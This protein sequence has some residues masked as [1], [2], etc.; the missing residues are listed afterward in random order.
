ML[1]LL[2][3]NEGVFHSLSLNLYDA[4]SHTHTNKQTGRHPHT[5]R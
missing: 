2:Q 1:N 3:Q 4:Q 5:Q